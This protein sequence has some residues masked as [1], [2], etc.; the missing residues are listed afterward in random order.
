MRWVKPGP[1]T[2]STSRAEVRAISPGSIVGS[3]T[4]SVAAPGPG[5]LSR[6]DRAGIRLRGGTASVAIEKDLPQRHARLDPEGTGVRSEPDL[7]LPIGGRVP[8]SAS[9]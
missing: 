3:P 2:R 7:Q 9:L 5:A 6:K 1:K 4:A 8:G